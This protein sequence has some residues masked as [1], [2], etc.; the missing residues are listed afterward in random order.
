MTHVFV[1]YTRSDAPFAR[2]LALRIAGAGLTPWLDDVID[3]G[4][5]WRETIDRAIRESFAMIVVMSPDAKASEYVTYEWAFAAGAGLEI[6]PL[7]L[8]PTRLHPRLEA[9]HHLDFTGASS[10]PWQTLL[11]RLHAIEQKRHVSGI[12]LRHDA[13][14]VV[15]RAV[16]SLDSQSFEERRQ[17]I[18]TLDQNNHPAAYDALLSALLHTMADVRKEALFRLARR[19]SFR[20]R[21]AVPGLIAA[22]RDGQVDVRAQAVRLLGRMDDDTAVLALVDALDDRDRRVSAAARMALITQGID[23]VARRTVETILRTG[24]YS[25]FAAAEQSLSA[26]GADARRVLYNALDHE[27]AALRLAAISMVGASQRLDALPRLLRLLDSADTNPA[28]I[29][30]LRQW[31][32]TSLCPELLRLSL[33]DAERKRVTGTLE[34]P[35]MSQV[36]AQHASSDDGGFDA[37]ET[38]PVFQ[39][40]SLPQ[41][42]RAAL[43]ALDRRAF[44]VLIAHLGHADGLLRRAAAITLFSHGTAVTDDLLAALY[45]ERSPTARENIVRLLGHLHDPRCIP[46]LIAC[47]E[48]GHLHLQKLAAD[49]LLAFNTDPARRAV[50]Q[51]RE[52]QQLRR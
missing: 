50:E 23:N 40:A 46:D 8:R 42:A 45:S 22:L 5:P 14:S 18:A 9:L 36:R 52:R 7:L 21:H 38:A 10:L 6:I 35:S 30:A 11:N 13:P 26:L 49:A 32:V 31:D 2:A 29:A 20:D 41:L 34:M 3:P 33:T 47:L 24:S 48:S 17:A 15:R 16:E 39:T 43:H 51:W 19:S 27:D 4:L 28:V 44:P 1:S 37:D 25:R 12:V